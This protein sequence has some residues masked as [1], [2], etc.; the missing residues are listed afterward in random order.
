MVR[1][2]NSYLVMLLALFWHLARQDI[3]K[4]LDNRGQQQECCCSLL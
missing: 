2:K 4:T 1:D 3:S